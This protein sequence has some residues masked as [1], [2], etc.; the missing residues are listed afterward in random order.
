MTFRD[1]HLSAARKVKAFRYRRLLKEGA[2]TLNFWNR[3]PSIRIG[4]LS[5]DWNAVGTDMRS[6]LSQYADECG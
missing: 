2:F 3:M 6:A 5:D 1:G 4:T